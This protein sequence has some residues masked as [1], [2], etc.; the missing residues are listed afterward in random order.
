MLGI[1]KL[2][3]RKFTLLELHLDVEAPGN[4]LDIIAAFFFNQIDRLRPVD[5]FASHCKLFFNKNTCLLDDPGRVS[6][7]RSERMAAVMFL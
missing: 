3:L 4:V 1:L 6:K 7:S 5:P 2:L